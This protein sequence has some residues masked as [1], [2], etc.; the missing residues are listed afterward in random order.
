MRTSA[1]AKDPAPRATTKSPSGAPTIQIVAAV[2]L[3][4]VPVV[5]RVLGEIGRNTLPI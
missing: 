2:H 4:K 3:S 1:S 5:S